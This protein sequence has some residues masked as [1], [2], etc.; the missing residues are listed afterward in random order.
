[1]TNILDRTTSLFFIALVIDGSLGDQITALK[2]EMSD[3][4]DS[5]RARNSPPHITL[6]PPFT[7]AN[8]KMEKSL[9]PDLR[10]FVSNLTRIQLQLT[11]F[12]AFKPRVIFVALAK[13]PDLYEQQSQL[14]GYLAKKYI[15]ISP[16]NR[17]FHPHI[18]IGF[19]DLAPERFKEAWEHFS[20]KTIDES[21][22]FEKITVLRHSVSQWIPHA[23]CPYGK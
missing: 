13:D 5:R 9:V 16:A 17:P 15:E 22:L 18:T 23:E 1:M 19:R 6:I 11:R 10:E 8:E 12:E 21:F 20:Q 14:Y 7:M 2:E 3:R 4:F